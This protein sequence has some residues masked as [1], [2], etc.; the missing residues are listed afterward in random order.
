MK[1]ILDVAS[2]RESDAATIASGVPGRELMD[3]AGRGIFRAAEWRL[4]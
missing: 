3:R 2:M 1:R 4:L